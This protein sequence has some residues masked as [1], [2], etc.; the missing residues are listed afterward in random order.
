MN[1]GQLVEYGTAEKIYRD[2][3]QDY[4]RQLLAAIPRGL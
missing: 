4:T 1:K 3:E 2:P